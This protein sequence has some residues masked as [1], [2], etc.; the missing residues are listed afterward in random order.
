[1]G[2]NCCKSFNAGPES[3]EESVNVVRAM[4]ARQHGEDDFTTRTSFRRA[5]R[6]PISSGGGGEPHG[7]PHGELHAVAGGAT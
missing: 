4:G 5:G 6:A 2:A 3:E 7:E 1:M